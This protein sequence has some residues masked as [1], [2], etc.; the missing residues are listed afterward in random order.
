LPRIYLNVMT[1]SASSALRTLGNSDLR[2]TA[3]GFGAWAVG[4]GD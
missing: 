2:I 3:I 4:G 1:E